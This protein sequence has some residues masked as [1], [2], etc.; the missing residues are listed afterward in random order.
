[1]RPVNDRPSIRRRLLALLLIPTA[2]IAAAATYGAYRA[3][4]APF[5]AAYDKALLDAALAIASNIEARDASGPTLSL[6]PDADAVLRSDSLDTIYYRVS[7]DDGHFI[8]G[9]RDLPVPHQGIEN[10]E[11]DDLR[12][13]GDP[14]RVVS[15]RVASAHGGSIV[16]VAETR[17]KRDDAR[18]SV[19]RS[20]LV[21]DAA[22]LAT[23][24]IVIWLGVE[25]AIEPLRNVE[26]QLAVRGSRDLEPLVT[27]GVPVEISSLINA[28]NRLFGALQEAEIAERSFLENAAHQ[29]R[30][31]LAAMLAHLELMAAGG[32]D[33]NSAQTLAALEG[34]RRLARTTQQL[35]A[36]A[37]SDA[38][39][40]TEL[41]LEDVSLAEVIKGC[42]ETRLAVTDA[43]RIDL[44]AEL[45]SAAIARG[46][47]WMLEEA[48]GNLT[49]NAIAATP[50]GG[51]V[52]L[53]CGMNAGCAWLEVGDTGVGIPVAE[54]AQVFERFY[55]ASN[56]RAAGSGLGLA[57]V[58]EVARLHRAA[59]T[60]EEGAGGRGTHVRMTFPEAIRLAPA[61]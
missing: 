61:S 35:L 33:V 15:Y 50:A 54:R 52:T 1:M 28:L 39:S 59:L 30:T 17:H 7:G 38:A 44:G 60:I 2:V 24:L 29:L 5:D 31:P 58:R 42:V 25:F 46:R 32:S 8:A 6:T 47:T 41:V 11:F 10:P 26:R 40:R 34:A 14:I 57:I 12:F 45:D 16:T 3:A 53:R 51:S 36:L 21:V 4:L 55:R 22:Q 49:D 20:S 18:D 43:A 48:L 13:G 27:D 37:R 9:D 23:A 56:A 19:L